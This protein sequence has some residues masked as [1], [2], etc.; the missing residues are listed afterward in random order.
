MSKNQMRRKTIMFTLILL[1]LWLAAIACNITDVCNGGT[2][3]CQA[4]AFSATESDQND[5]DSDVPPLKHALH[6]IARRAS[7]SVAADDRSF[8]GADPDA[9]S[10]LTTSHPAAALFSVVQAPAD[11]RHSWQFHLRTAPEPRAPSSV[12]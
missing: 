1:P 12:S 3:G 9:I 7:L 6:H 2:P 8:S 4:G 10:A 5:S 11:L